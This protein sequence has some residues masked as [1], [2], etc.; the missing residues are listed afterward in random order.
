M[1]TS[2]AVASYCLCSF[3]DPR[4]P[5]TD[6][7]R[8]DMKAKE[9]KTKYLNKKYFFG[10][11]SPAGRAGQEK[12]MQAGGGWG[13]LLAERPPTE[14]LLEVQR[15]VRKRL[16][17]NWL[18]RFLVTK[19]FLARQRPHVGMDDAVEDV[20]IQKKKKSQAIWRVRDYSVM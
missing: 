18:P 12:V 13:K 14:L 6:E 19:E 15:Y 2:L 1:V 3:S 16:E 20:L 17:K 9:I 11:H 10:P 7:K 8:R 4:I 5:Y